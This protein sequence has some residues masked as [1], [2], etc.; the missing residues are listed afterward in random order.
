M[1]PP[2][3]DPHDPLGPRFRS[4]PRDHPDAALDPSSDPAERSPLFVWF[5]GL[6]LFLA[7]TVPLGEGPLAQAVQTYT[8]EGAAILLAVFVLS[9]GDWTRERFLAALTAPLNLALAAFLA[10]LGIAA[11]HSS[12][13]D[14][15]RADIWRHVGGVLLFLSIAYGLSP[16]K[17]LGPFV[18]MLG[19][20]GAAAAVVGL[21]SYRPGTH[22]FTMSGAFGNAELMGG[23]LALLLPLVL[24]ASRMDPEPV[25][26]FAA[27]AC[28][29]VLAGG[30]LIARNRSSWAGT[31]VAL[32][33]MGALYLAFARRGRRLDARQLIIPTLVLAISA[34]L[35]VGISGSSS[36]IVEKVGRLMS[37]GGEHSVA[38][39]MGMYNK[40]LKLIRKRPVFGWGPGSFRIQ[41][42]LFYDPNLP[43]RSQPEMMRTGATDF[44]NAHNTFLQMAADTGIPGGVLYGLVFVAFLGTGVAAVSRM[45]PGFRQAVVLASVASVAGVAVTTL[46][47]PML[48]WPQTS[49]VFWIVM[50]LGMSAAGLGERGAPLEETAREKPD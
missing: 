11:Y 47:N 20:V 31:L 29:V 1:I 14:Y 37:P 46:A 36:W 16:R 34:G 3:R 48:E 39:R 35:F 44:E 5:V 27:T 49:S 23:F 24:A 18:T 12:L 32:V 19:V 42:A 26:R 15:S 22:Y 4:E 50:G 43:T 8:L 28:A 40:A 38:A 25:R 21:C 10:W 17:L 41:Q 7:S 30:L 45:R 33:V 2:T 6:V 13:P 9:R